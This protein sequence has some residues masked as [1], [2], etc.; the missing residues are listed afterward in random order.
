VEAGYR[1][2]AGIAC[3]RMLAKLAAGLHKPD[4]QTVLLPSEAAAF[5][6]GLPARARGP[7]A[8]P[9]PARGPGAPPARTAPR[10][11][12]WPGRRPSTRSMPALDGV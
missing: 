1:A 11:P 5:V 4:D 7:P 6:A 2:S 9:R 8:R 10:A 3:N 12:A